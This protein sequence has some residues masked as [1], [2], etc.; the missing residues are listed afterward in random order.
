MHSTRRIAGRRGEFVRRGTRIVLGAA[1]AALAACIALGVAQTSVAQEPQQAPL[2]WQLGQGAAPIGSNLAEIDL[3][4]QYVFLD[5]QGTRKLME[6]THNPL[7]GM[8]RATVA[9]A[10]D[11]EQ[12]FLVFEYEESGYVPDDEKEDLDPDA[13]LESIRQGTEAANVERRKQGWDPLTIVGWHERPHYDLLSNNLR[14]AI[15][16]ESGGERSMNRIIKL[17]GRRG[18]MTATLVA[19][20]DEFE[21]AAVQVDQLLSGY[22]Y[23]PGNTY[24][25][26]VPGKDKLAKYGLTALI[27]GGTGAA[28][29]KS[30]LLARL[31]K[32]IVAGLA[33]LGAGVKRFLFG[34][35]SSKH[36]MEG[37]IG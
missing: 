21:N 27:V 14:W 1:A 13:I 25:E 19:T 15:I 22:R 24:A 36:D 11:L 23:R 12:W 33:A 20:P 2:R 3:D 17:L 5:A 26:Y 34:G 29:V 35:R 30:G 37:P 7:T 10:S 31:W 9:P 28:L 16:G 4:E 6:L 18:V 32:P 8:E